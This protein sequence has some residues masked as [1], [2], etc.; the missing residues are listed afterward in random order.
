[1]SAE[2]SLSLLRRGDKNSDFKGMIEET[3]LEASG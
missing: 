3:V 2:P 1:M